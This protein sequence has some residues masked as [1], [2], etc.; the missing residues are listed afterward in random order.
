[1]AFPDGDEIRALLPVQDPSVTAEQCQTWVD[2]WVEL[3]RDAAGQPRDGSEETAIS[4]RIVRMGAWAD[5]EEKLLADSG[6]AAT[7]SEQRAV[8]TRRQWADKALERFDKD[9]STLHEPGE[10]APATVRNVSPGPLW[11]DEPFTGN[12]FLD[13]SEPYDQLRW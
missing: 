8:M 2:E 4:R 9:R 3:V 11:P 6:Y 13:P 7:E 5:A 12:R 10:P 1:M